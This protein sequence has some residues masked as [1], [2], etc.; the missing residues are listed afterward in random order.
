[1]TMF[2]NGPARATSTMSRRGF[3]SALKLTGTGLAYPNRNGVRRSNKIAGIRI[4]P[5]G[6]MCLSGFMVTRPK[7]Y[8]VSSPRRWATKPCAASCRVIARTTG[9]THTDAVARNVSSCMRLPDDCVPRDSELNGEAL[10]TLSRAARAGDRY[11]TH[12]NR[13]TADRVP[14][15]LDPDQIPPHSTHCGISVST[16]GSFLVKKWVADPLQ[17]SVSRCKQ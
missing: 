14:L 16:L 2:V 5:T 7:R 3:L 6:S 4:V 15:F 1:I 13:L 10:T 9:S 17:L 8:A 12:I 11:R